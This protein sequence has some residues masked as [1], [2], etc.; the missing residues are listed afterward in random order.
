MEMNDV[1]LGCPLGERLQRH[2]LRYN[3]I[4]AG[5][6]EPQSRRP[7]R[8]KRA[9][10]YRITAG[11]QRHLVAQLDELFGQPDTTLSVPP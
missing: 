5:F 7:Y 8:N 9:A 6:S 11:E 1:Q 10:G 3:R 4:D 2:C